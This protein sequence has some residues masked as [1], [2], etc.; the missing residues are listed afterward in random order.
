MPWRLQ[1][2]DLKLIISSQTAISFFILRLLVFL[3]ISMPGTLCGESYISGA[4]LN[5]SP[6]MQQR[7]GGKTLSKVK[8]PL[9]RSLFDGE[10]LALLRNPYF[11]TQ[12]ALHTYHIEYVKKFKELLKHHPESLPCKSQKTISEWVD[13]FEFFTLSNEYDKITV[14]FELN[15]EYRSL[16]KLKKMGLEI[17]SGY[18]YIKL[19]NF[20]PDHIQFFFRQRGFTE[21]QG[22]TVYTRYIAVKRT[23]DNSS[24]HSI[25]DH[26]LAHA[27]INS[28]LGL[29]GIAKLPRWFHE[30]CATYLSKYKPKPPKMRYAAGRGSSITRY[31]RTK[32]YGDYWLVF[33]YIDSE[34]KLAEFIKQCIQDK[35]ADNALH[36]IMGV[37]SYDELLDKA[38][39]QQDKIIIA[40]AFA[41]GAVG[42][43][44]IAYASNYYHKKEDKK[45]A[46][47]EI[48]LRLNPDGTMR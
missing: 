7:K 10:K 30:G 4:L 11:A 33:D 16:V 6:M 47:G 9:I 17:P 22:V 41:L 45:L 14:S 24:Q 36:K 37:S 5:Q 27:Y 44:L 3:A 13:L 12:E 19:G 46:E 42:W 25:I 1:Y 28:L 35:S 21:T 34:G 26:E 32:D 48:A 43:L 15:D 18:A 23:F 8:S 2:I 20:W 29:D 39:K 31:Q 40:W 38:S